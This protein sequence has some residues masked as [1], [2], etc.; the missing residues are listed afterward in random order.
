AYLL[1]AQKLLQD[2]YLRDFPDLALMKGRSNYPCLVADTHAAAAPCL[3]GRTYPECD[4]CPYFRAKDVAMAAHGTVMNYAYHL[5]ETSHAG[6]FGRRDLL[7]LDEAHGVEA[8]LMRFVEVRLSDA[9][10]AR[11]GVEVRL[12]QGDDR[13]G[14]LE[15]ALDLAPALAARVR[16][17][18]AR[19]EELPPTS[20]AAAEAL[21][22]RRWLEGTIQGLSLL[23]ESSDAGEVDW[24]VETG[25][26]ADGRTLAFRPVDVA[27][28]AEPL[29]FR[30]GRRVL[31]MSATILDPDTYLAS[32]GLDPDAVAV[33]RAA[34]T[35]PPERRP[36]R[37]RPAARLT[38]HRLP[39]ELPRLVDALAELMRRHPREKGVV[40]AHSYRIADAI[41]RGLP[42]E[43][44]SRLRTHDG[45][46]GRDDALARHLDDAGPTV[47]LTPSMTEGVDLA[48]DAARWQ[49]ICKIPWPYLGDPQVAARRDRDPEWYAWRTCL[50]VVQ[51][52]GRSV[53]SAEDYAVTYLL[54][55]DFPS[56]LR[57]QR[58]RLPDW[59][60]EAIE[61]DAVA[62][63]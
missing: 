25:R 48:G 50:T 63:P 44:R 62:I 23:G 11:A 42:Q 1:T 19:L 26:D 52:Y 16:V 31:L 47:L 54:D 32:L 7:V 21:R 12:P 36:L 43:L 33:V 20:A 46:A 51:A 15:G 38:R 45:A 18:G 2:Q 28:L 14:L 40:H 41:R 55:A 39:S 4:E 13:F 9:E 10:L 8:A 57:R 5:A 56:F 59:F 35:F 58:A 61:A 34:S 3:L 30:Y 24:V 60:V 53:R 27:A 29:L 17:L 22:T 49:A 37:L 6:G